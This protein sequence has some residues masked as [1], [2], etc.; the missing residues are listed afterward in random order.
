MMKVSL[1]VYPGPPAGSARGFGL[2][3]LPAHEAVA[4]ARSIMSRAEARSWPRHCAW[5]GP[6]GQARVFKFRLGTVMGCGRSFQ[7]LLD[8]ALCGKPDGPRRHGIAAMP[9]GCLSGFAV[10]RA[11]AATLRASPGEER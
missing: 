2:R 8:T 3:A 9:E 5:S 7:K 11:G 1:A 4:G 6:E 10:L